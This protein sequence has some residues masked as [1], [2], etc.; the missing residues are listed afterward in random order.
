MATKITTGQVFMRCCDGDTR[1]PRPD[2]RRFWVICG[3]LAIPETVPLKSEHQY[4]V[5]GILPIAEVFGDDAEEVRELLGAKATLG[6]RVHLED[7]A[8]DMT[9]EARGM[10]P[11]CLLTAPIWRV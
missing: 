10:T 2:G 4:V 1:A 6:L 9:E 5:E 11:D 7:G 8:L 3:V